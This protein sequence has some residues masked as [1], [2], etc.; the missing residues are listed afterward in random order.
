MD[1]KH[2]EIEDKMDFKRFTR[3]WQT[4]NDDRT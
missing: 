4:I 2:G 1:K 3:K